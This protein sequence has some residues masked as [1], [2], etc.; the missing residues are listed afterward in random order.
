MKRFFVIFAFLYALTGLFYKGSGIT[1]IKDIQT[2][3]DPELLKLMLN[4]FLW[5]KDLKNAYRVAK[6]GVK[7][8]PK[9]RF[10]LKKAG[11]ISL[12]T[13]RIKEAEDYY[14]RLYLLTGDKK[15]RKKLIDLSISLKDYS[16]SVRLLEE[17]IKENNLKNWKKL[18]GLY[19]KLGQPDKALELLEKIYKKHKK[20]EYLK[21]IVK[22]QLLLGYTKQAFKNLEKLKKTGDLDSKYALYLSNFLY[23]KKKYDQSLNTLLS[24][25][26]KVSV[27]NFDYWRTLSDLAWNLRDYRNAVY[28]SKILIN[29]G[30]GRNVDYERLII[31]LQT[32]KRADYKKIYRYSYEGW[33]KFHSETFF[34][35]LIDSLYKQKKYTKVIKTIQTLEKKYFDRLKFYDYIWFYY[36]NSYLKLGKKAKAVEIYQKAIKYNPENTD[37]I[38]SFLWTLID[39]EDEKRLKKYLKKYEYIA[40]GDDKLDLVYGSAYSLL[41]NSLKSLYYLNREIRKNP[42][43]PDTLI[44]YGDTTDLSGRT[45]QAYY[46]RFKA[47]KILKEKLKKDPS[48]LKDKSFLKEI[49]YISFYFVPPESIKKLLENGKKYLNK[50]DYYNL[51]I[52]WFLMRD[53][54]LPAEYIINRFKK[55]KPWMLL[56]VALKN[57]D[58]D[59]INALLEKKRSRL[60][61]RDRVEAS[62]RVDRVKLSEQLA[63]EGMEKNRF[64]SLLY[65]QFRDIIMDNESVFKVKGEYQNREKNEQFTLKTSVKYYL[66]SNYYIYG[67]VSKSFILSKN[68]DLFRYLPSNYTETRLG[69]GRNLSRYK[70]EAGM[71][72][73]SGLKGNTGFYGQ[74]EYY[75]YNRLWTGVK[76]GI[77]QRSDETLYLYYG[78][79]SDYIKLF[80]SYNL[81][82]K[83]GI[84]SD[85][86]IASYKS[87]DGKNIGKGKIF[88]VEGYYKIRSGYPDFTVS[89]YSRNGLF[90]EK[91]QKG[92]IN[93]IS[94][95]YNPDVLPENYCEFGGNFFFGYEHKEYYTRIFRPFMS[96][97][98]YFNCVTG[99]GYGF[100]LG[101]GGHLFQQDHISIGTSYYK[102]TQG[103]NDFIIRFYVNYNLWF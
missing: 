46:Y 71:T 24:I 55:G 81:T 50:K 8:F 62:L 68:G 11:D 28:A 32:Q 20:S 16:L 2:V 70:W 53:K 12:W 57:W 34:Y 61:I 13:G 39:L 102:G 56:N 83:I 9:S 49:I 103:T 35:Y 63:F 77:S 73:N 59:R 52:T 14:Y 42:N 22:I 85:F 15:L 33:K 67:A 4:S 97:G 80:L 3:K 41:Q 21:E 36:G 95:I 86:S 82:E 60:P 29:S 87:V 69:I 17:E 94:V 51:L 5:S 45:D 1:S 74:F 64:D 23:L 54:N 7:L 84:N 27:K 99:F 72:Y 91:N 10:W 90:S 78:G 47:W 38:A 48:L 79:L 44:L 100:D 88:N 89:I 25:K 92:K 43:D 101:I 40:K 58:K 75:S 76:V 6:K 65:R 18:A 93:S 30:K 37:L 26:D 31:Y 66:K 96:L 98:S 19:E